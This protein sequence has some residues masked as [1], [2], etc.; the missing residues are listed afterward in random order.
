MSTKPIPF[1]DTFFPNGNIDYPE[2][3]EQEI[4]P[5]GL[6]Y[7]YIGYSFLDGL[8]NNVIHLRDHPTFKAVLVNR[9][10]D[11]AD[12]K[13]SGGISKTD[14]IQNIA[15]G[16]HHHTKLH[17]FKDDV[18]FLVKTEENVYWFIYYDRDVSDCSI[19]RFR[20]DV[21]FDDVY[22]SMCQFIVEMDHVK[23]YGPAEAEPYLDIPNS[24]FRGWISW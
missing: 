9:Y 19:G 18:A 1:F 23:N 22:A 8:V 16:K 2:F 14:I 21:P 10:Y 6:L 24:A 4:L 13:E 7:C 12:Q 11:E 17:E 5:F 20:S 3:A 15:N